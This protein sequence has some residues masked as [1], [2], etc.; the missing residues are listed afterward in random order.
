MCL[1]SNFFWTILVFVVLPHLISARI[2]DGKCIFVCN[3]CKIITKDFYFLDDVFLVNDMKLKGLVSKINDHGDRAD[4]EMP[5][6][7]MD[8]KWD[9]NEMPYEVDEETIS[10][11][12]QVKVI[13]NTIDKMNLM[14]CG[15]FKIRYVHI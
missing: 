5:K 11:T 1:F 13:N 2:K 4:H 14:T 15:C 7:C 10:S 8:S 6:V 3:V 12:M 9:N